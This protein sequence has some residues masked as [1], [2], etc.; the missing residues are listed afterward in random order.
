MPRMNADFKPLI[1]GNRGESEIED[2]DDFSVGYNAK[3]LAAGRDRS[4]YGLP[5]VIST[6]ETAKVQPTR[7]Y[8]GRCWIEPDT[9]S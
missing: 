7:I 5:R 9:L 1:N 6:D 3:E 2:E 8:Q 4:G